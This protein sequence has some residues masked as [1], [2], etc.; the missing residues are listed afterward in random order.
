M[1]AYV[2][3]LHPSARRRFCSQKQPLRRELN[4]RQVLFGGVNKDW[5]VPIRVRAADTHVYICPQDHLVHYMLT[6]IARRARRNSL[7]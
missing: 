2:L 6:Y 5:P 3:Y 4:I 1:Q 7:T